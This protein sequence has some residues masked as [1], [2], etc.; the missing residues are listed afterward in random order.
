MEDNT[1]L[2]GQTIELPELE[3][4]DDYDVA[5]GASIDYDIL[6]VLNSIGTEES[7]SIIQL[8]LP[9]IRQY[10]HDKQVDFCRQILEKAKEQY[11]YEFPENISIENQD[12]ID[13]VY[14]FLKFLEFNHIDFLASVWR[15]LGADLRNDD[16]QKFCEE[17][18]SFVI[19]TIEHESDSQNIRGLSSIFLRTY[20]KADMI[21]SGV[22]GSMGM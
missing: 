3:E 2:L 13:D 18:D 5:E 16:L 19:E 22:A 10:P 14:N 12:D 8:L 7:K 1:T 4:Q 20:N 21:D 11:D 15:I 9:D 6:E 17:N